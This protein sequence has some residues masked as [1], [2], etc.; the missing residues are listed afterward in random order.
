[1]NAIQHVLK[2][3]RNREWVERIGQLHPDIQ[4]YDILY[5]IQTSSNKKQT[6]EELHSQISENGPAYIWRQPEFN[7]YREMME[8]EHYFQL[9]P[10]EFEEGVMECRCGSHKTISYQRQTRSADEGATT[11]VKCVECKHSW[12]HNN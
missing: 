9:N 8:E 7:Q 3:P 1:M 10:I 12:R 11:F 2:N 6:L 4:I 5:I